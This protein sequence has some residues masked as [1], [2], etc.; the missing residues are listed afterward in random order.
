M[1]NHIFTNVITKLIKV[2]QQQTKKSLGTRMGSWS[3]R[4]LSISIKT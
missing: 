1:K 3:F 4:L 2:I